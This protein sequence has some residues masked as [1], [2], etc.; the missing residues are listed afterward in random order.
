MS[1]V[2]NIRL[3]REL[4]KIF[5]NELKPLKFKVKYCNNE[6]CIKESK[7]IAGHLKCKKR[8]ISICGFRNLC[9]DSHYHYFNYVPEYIK[10]EQI[11]KGRGTKVES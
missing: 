11:Q 6:W 7:N 4:N 1:G 3:V 8:D 9:P 10:E 2:A 5:S